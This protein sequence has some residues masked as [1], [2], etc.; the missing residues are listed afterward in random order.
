MAV[1][2][3]VTEGGGDAGHGAD[4][5]S[6]DKMRLGDRQSWFS[7]NL[8]SEHKAQASR[9]L[10]LAAIDGLASGRKQGMSNVRITNGM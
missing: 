10:A 6:V 3:S 5:R 4:L 1:S 2:V 9:R 7:G 8:Q